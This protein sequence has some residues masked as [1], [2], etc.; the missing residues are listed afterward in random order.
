MSK[1]ATFTFP[2]VSFRHLD[3]PF[4]HKGIHEYFAVVETANLPDLSD[5]KD[6]NVRDAKLTGEVPDAIRK[7]F[8][9]NPEMFLFMNRGLVLSVA[10][11]QLD[12]RNSTLTIVLEDRNLHGLLD[13]GHT[14]SIVKEETESLTV[15]QYI[16]IELL[17]G[18]DSEGIV[19]V[20]DARNT[21]KPVREQ[22]L[23]NL[24]NKFVGLKNALSSSAFRDQISYSEYEVDGA[25]DLKPIGVR[26][27][28]AILTLFDKKSFGD[29]QHPVISYNAKSKALEHF[30]ANPKEYEKIFPLAEEILELY[31]WVKLELPD[32]YNKARAQEANVSGGR[33]GRLTGVTYYTGQRSGKL[34][35]LNKTTKYG[36][37]DGFTYP[38]LAAFRALLEEHKG[39]YKW[40]K[41]L[42]PVTLLK[43]DLGTKLA[44]TIGTFAHQAQNP[45]KVGKTALVWQSCYQNAQLAYL[46][47]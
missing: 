16:R 7:T 13:G 4:Q 15:P 42:D 33:F 43:G 45:T 39:V 37:P 29:S 41:G 1:T 9:A 12:N 17:E 14:Y 28:V 20:V 25:G 6:I 5:W 22:S 3:T 21:S 8:Q 40:G 35:F 47:A 24:A 38:V 18:L 32:L 36:V 23:M 2:V 19:D 31:D 26:D 11:A 44:N 27:V 34:Y 30:S 46:Q 10:K